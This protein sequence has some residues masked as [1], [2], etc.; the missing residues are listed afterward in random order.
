[1]K[2]IDTVIAHHEETHWSCGDGCC[3]NWACDSVFTYRGKEYEFS[4]YSSEETLS[5]FLKEIIGIEF[6]ETSNYTDHDNPEN[7]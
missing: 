5:Q 1:M 6:Q 4:G 2:T 3:D 7:N